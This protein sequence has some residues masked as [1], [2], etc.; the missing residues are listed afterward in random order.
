MTYGP[1]VPTP[2]ALA[3]PF[4]WISV[5]RLEGSHKMALGHL[6]T[7]Q[8]R[9]LTQPGRLGVALFLIP[10]FLAQPNKGKIS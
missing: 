10:T 1:T 5:C 8:S 3:S 7:E 6:F 4:V 2:A 9:L